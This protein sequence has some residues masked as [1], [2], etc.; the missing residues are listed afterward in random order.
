MLDGLAVLVEL[1][2]VAKAI[3][4]EFLQGA[5][6]AALNRVCYGC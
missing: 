3:I 4:L 6:K 2:S 1:L 5:K